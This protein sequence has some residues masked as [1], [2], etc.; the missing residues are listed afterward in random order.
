[1]GQMRV[2]MSAECQVPTTFNEMFLFNAAVMGFSSSAW[3][4][5]SDSHMPWTMDGLGIGIPKR[6]EVCL[7]LLR[8]LPGKIKEFQVE[9][10]VYQD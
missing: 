4:T 5:G 2:E 6:P 3:D 9:V 7:T 1:M 10:N 8:A